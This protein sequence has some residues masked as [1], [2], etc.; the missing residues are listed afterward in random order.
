ML[1]HIF[2]LSLFPAI[3]FFTPPA[4]GQGN[5]PQAPIA[6][7]VKDNVEDGACQ[8]KLK[9]LFTRKGDTLTLKLD[10]GKSKTYVGNR[11]AC[12]GENADDAKCLVF[13]VLKYFPKARSYLIER[14][15]YECGAYL[16]VSQH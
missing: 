15:L 16:L 2:A 12:D 13:V 14:G 7:E 6:C 5:T 10:G 4:P 8:N 11:A 9:G 1:K 3:F